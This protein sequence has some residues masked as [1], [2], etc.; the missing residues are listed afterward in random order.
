MGEFRLLIMTLL[1]NKNAYA[2]SSH[3]MVG[4]TKIPFIV[5]DWY[6]N[7]CAFLYEKV[8]KHGGLGA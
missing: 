2:L 4:K 6:I 5:A 8:R 1:E 7:H 3:A